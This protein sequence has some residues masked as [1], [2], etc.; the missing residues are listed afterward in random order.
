LFI[1]AN[2]LASWTLADLATL[3][4]LISLELPMRDIARKL[5]RPEEAVRQKAHRVAMADMKRCPP[6]QANRWTFLSGITD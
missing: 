6:I 2:N 1:R 4:K 3:R 5:H